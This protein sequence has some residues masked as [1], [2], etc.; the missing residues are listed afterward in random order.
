MTGPGPFTVLSTMKNEGPFLLDWV[1]HHKALG[2][3]HVVICTNDCADGT[4]A[5]VRRLAEMGEAVHH[6]TRVPARGS[7]HM[8]AL[9]Q[10]W[11]RPEVA[12]AGW[13]WIADADEYLSVHLGDGRVQALA[14]AATA[15]A[16]V[17]TVPW[18]VFGS[19]GRWTFEDAPVTQLFRRAEAPRDR[20][21]AWSK[22]LTRGGAP[23]AG[24]QVH[25]PR[26]AA[27]AGRS[28]R[29]E[30]PGGR[31]FVPGRHPHAVPPDWSG[32]QVSHYAL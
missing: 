13:V 19:A 24:P 2:F 20:P 10:A 4:A 32:A 16:D 11:A 1:A 3:D 6:A 9:R 26:V 17:V 21:P 14:A 28:L 15:R 30:L 31:P 25:I 23:V 22:S 7:I 5:M 29:V 12:G 8:A 18:R 27:T